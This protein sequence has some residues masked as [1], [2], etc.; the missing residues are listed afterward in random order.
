MKKNIV[1]FITDLDTGGA[2]IML[3]KLLTAIDHNKYNILVVSLIDKGT[4]GGKIEELGIKVYTLNLSRR[5]PLTFALFSLPFEL[6][7]FQPNA[8]HGW[9]YH[10]NLLSSFISLFFSN[11]D[12]IWGI[13]HSLYDIDKEKLLTKLVI[14]LC[15]FISKKCKHIIFNS[16]VS[17]K[18]HVEYGFSKDN[19]SIIHNG[20]DA[21]IFS[22]NGISE[23]QSNNLKTSLKIPKNTDIIGFNAR[24]HPMKGHN[25]FI[26][27]ANKIIKKKKDVCFILVGPGVTNKR[28][29][30]LIPKK[31]R[32]FFFLL[33]D[34][35]DIV[36]LNSIFDVSI[37]CSIWGEGFSNS[38]CES[39]LMEVPC[40]ATNVGE[41]EFILNNCGVIIESNN[42]DLLSSS[43]INL[44]SK[45]KDE[46]VKIGK[47]E[48][49]RIVDNF[50]IEVIC[51]KYES[52]YE[53]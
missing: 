31:I 27:A 45:S 28:L 3:L 14:Y 21:N 41:S 42:E 16:N 36:E 26:K 1:H 20:F 18:Q 43:I 32:P 48:R 53:A 30:H 22:K 25:N 52:I 8:F 38:I 23:L 11:V 44:L 7:R 19:C 4:I 10:A 37:N 51:K 6:K 40:I 50:S 34:R 29:H 39:M 9:M 33:G 24:F 35:S 15:K 5:T 17:L 46:R 49:A 2:E 12:V 13:R 47:L